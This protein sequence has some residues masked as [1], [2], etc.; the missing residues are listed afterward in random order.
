MNRPCDEGEIRLDAIACMALCCYL[1][2]M[3]GIDW[4][5]AQVKWIEERR[6]E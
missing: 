5:N 1:D 4:Y 2:G 6:K 3:R